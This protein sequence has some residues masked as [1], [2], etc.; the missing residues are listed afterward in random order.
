MNKIIIIA[1]FLLGCNH[2]NNEIV[3]LAEVSN[4]K[5]LKEVAREF[6]KDI[7]GE[8]VAISPTIRGFYF[9]PKNFQKR[10]ITAYK[11]WRPLFAK[12][13]NCKLA[14]MFQIDYEGVSLLALFSLP[15]THSVK[16][17]SVTALLLP[18]F[19]L[20][21]ELDPKWILTYLSKGVHVLAIN[22]EGEE[23]TIANDWK[24]TCEDGMR[25]SHWLQ[26]KL[27]AKIIILGKSMGAIPASYVAANTPHASL[28]LENTIML[29]P[30]TNKEWL[31][32]VQGRILAIQSLNSRTILQLPKSATLMTV[33]GTHFGPYWGDSGPTW[34]E[35]EKDQ[36]KLLKFLME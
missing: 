33:M 16:K 18:S 23:K 22:Y 5:R 4:P 21:V 13:K 11:K 31:K 26:N 2:Q 29:H 3:S 9:N 24:S 7:G 10:E 36:I 20:P 1:L 35:Y 17:D 32:N 27:R 28:I 19:S 25:A 14:E 8:E 30:L 6:L 12:P 34:Y 15:K